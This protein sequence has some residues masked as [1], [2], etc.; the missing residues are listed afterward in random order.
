MIFTYTTQHVNL[1][2]HVEKCKKKF[3]YTYMA[4]LSKCFWQGEYKCIY[5]I[6]VVNIP[7]CNPQ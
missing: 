6:S 3:N 2:L 4:L 7:I 5:C 1:H